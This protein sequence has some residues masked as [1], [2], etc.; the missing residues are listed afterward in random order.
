M[1]LIWTDDMEWKGDEKQMYDMAH[2]AA[3][4]FVLPATGMGSGGGIVNPGMSVG[5]FAIIAAFT[6]DPL[7]MDKTVQ[8]INVISILCFLLFVFLKIDPKEKEIWLA[9]IALAAVSPLAV[10]FSRKIWAQDLLPIFSFFIILTNFYRSKGWSA[11][12]WGLTGAII[13]QVH[14]SGFFFAFGLFVFSLVHDYYNK[15]RFRWKYWIAGSLIGSISLVPW[16]SFLINNPHITNVSFWNIF[17]FNFYIYWFLDSL[18]LNIYYSLREDFWLFIREPVI[19]G[20]PTYIV[21][22]MH[23]FLVVT[24]IFTLNKIM[25]YMYKIF[26]QLKQKT[27]LESFFIG[28]SITKFYLFSILLGLGIFLTLSGTTIC[29]HYLICAFPFSYIFLAKMLRQHKKL[30]H[31]VIIAQMLIT[32][33]FLFYIHK[34]NGAEQGDYGKSYHAQV[35]KGK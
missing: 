30:L 28:M 3:D 12:L 10:L 11:F 21:A 19:I 2:E 35:E 5:V 22:V 24:S 27:F 7:A 15:I 14:M 29:Q 17:Q 16:I 34:N 9:G 23:L 31:T 4:K 20:I 32:A 6:N 18:G 1:R 8:I 26:Y 25:K 33:T 13:G